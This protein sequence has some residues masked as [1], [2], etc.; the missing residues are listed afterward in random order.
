[1][2]RVAVTFGLCL[3]TI[4]SSAAGE[5]RI[6]RSLK[7]LAPTER[8]V[9]LCDYTA[10]QHIRKAKGEFRPDRVVADGAK[11]PTFDKNTVIA[12]GAAFRSRGKWYSLT[13]RCTAAPENLKVESFK[14]EIG[15]E[16]P[17]AKWA[18]YGLWQ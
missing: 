5:S 18:A 11:D 16:I 7:M 1:M 2:R 9:Q 8:L 3:V 6:E 4:A 15:G 10:M 17:E 12:D 14:Y 13:F